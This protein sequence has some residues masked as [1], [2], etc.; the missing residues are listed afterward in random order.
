MSKTRVWI[1]L[2]IMFAISLAAGCSSKGDSDG[3]CDCDTPQIK[4]SQ[5]KVGDR[6]PDFRLPDHTGGYVQLSDYTGKSNVVIAFFPA[7]FTPV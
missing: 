5:L 4:N 3:D 2:S 6:A 1:F 7:A